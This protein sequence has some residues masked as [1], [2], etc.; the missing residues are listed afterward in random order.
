LSRLF[1][2][3]LGMAVR[4]EREGSVGVIVLDRPPAN[5]YDYDFLREFGAAVDDARVDEE[6]RAVIVRSASERFFS[7][8][9]DLKAFQ[10]GSLRRRAMTVLL[11]HEVFRKMESTP[12]VFI[13]AINGNAYGGGLEL[14]LAC[15]FRFA[16]EG[17]YR[18]GLSEV[19]VG[20]FPGNGGTQRLPR[21][22]GLS[23]GLE[24]IVEGATVTPTQAKEIGLVDRLF[25]DQRTL[26]EGALEYASKLAAGPTEAIGHAKVAAALGFAAPMDAGLAIER[27]AIMRVFASDD[28]GEGISA[29]T[30]KRKPQYTGR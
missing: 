6:V 20:L 12:L 18:M 19:N 26:Q 11:G 1:I 10:A 22:V 16:C 17:D 4:L 27:E 29:F 21:L 2:I 14:A 15:D 30:E 3:I 5:A 9:A 23:R 24:M 28:A 7:A 25:P 8:G 13:A